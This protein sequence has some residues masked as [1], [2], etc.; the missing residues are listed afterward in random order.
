MPTRRQFLTL[1]TAGAL[2]RLLPA[3]ARPPR[4]LVIGA[5]LAGLAAARALHAAGYRVRVLEARA[6]LGGRLWTDT[7]WPDAP[8]DLG[9][10]WIHGVDGNPLTTLAQAAS[11]PL[12]DTRYDRAILYDSDGTPFSAAQTRQLDRLERRL[13]TAIAAAQAAPSDRSL[14]AAVEAA[15]DWPTAPARTRQLLAYLLNSRY[16]QEY[17][18]SA[19][20]LSTWWHDDDN[21][22]GGGDA[23]LRDGYGA[24]VDR[25]ADGLLIVRNQ[26]V[27]AVTRRADGVQVTTANGVWRADYALLTLPLGVLQ[28]GSVRFDPPLPAAKQRAIAA[29]GV[30]VLNKCFLRFAS[31]F[32]PTGYDWLGYLPPLASAGRWVEWV[33]LAR[34]SGQPILLGFNAA[35]FGRSLEAWDDA[36]IVADALRTLRVM[37]GHDVPAPQAA[38]VTR[39]AADPYARGSYSFNAL[40]STPTQRDVLAQPVGGRL[41]FA[42]EA[43]SRPYFGTA[44]GAYLSGLRA[45]A[46]VRAAAGV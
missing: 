41:F 44:H 35:D 6:R 26:P 37:F 38:I 4:V 24:L 23:L 2:G 18:G 3:V 1:A 17:A 33:S 16:E 30:G 45:A 29:L 15:F 42:G 46:E 20:D 43:T 40:G 36:A 22:F 12:I 39:W 5:G 14:R 19:A 28:A 21:A 8:V 34:P 7:R 27:T 31:A 32:W 25:L 9:A 10:S 11:V 13:G